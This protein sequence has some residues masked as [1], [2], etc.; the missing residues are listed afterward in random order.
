MG[1]W[2]SRDVGLPHMAATPYTT[3]ADTSAASS[4]DGCGHTSGPIRSQRIG[5]VR[6]VVRLASRTKQFAHISP[7]LQVVVFAFQ[8]FKKVFMPTFRGMRFQQDALSPRVT[9]W[10]V[11][12]SSRGSRAW[13]EEGVRGL[14]LL[15]QTEV[16]RRRADMKNMALSS[17]SVLKMNRKL[18]DRKIS[19][20]MEG[21]CKS[22]ASRDDRS[23]FATRHAAFRDRRRLIG[24]LSLIISRPL[25]VYHIKN[26][27]RMHK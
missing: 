22:K 1:P 5:S 2:G 7:R 27:S 3:S 12:T 4:K 24:N 13:D 21:K 19:V 25:F 16:A 14:A 15:R 10:H 26:A 6:L 8:F 18:K 20:D 11:V 23:Q 9:F 17:Y